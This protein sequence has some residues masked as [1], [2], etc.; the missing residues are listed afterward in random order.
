MESAL[1]VAVTVTICWEGMEEGAVYKTV[2]M[3]VLVKVP[4]EGLRDQRTPVV[5]PVTVAVNCWELEA[6]RL[7]EEGETATVI[8]GGGVEANW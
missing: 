8:G 2:D 1:E 4:M 5:E 6:L 3:P 7:I